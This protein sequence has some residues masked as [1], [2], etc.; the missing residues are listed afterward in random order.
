MKNKFCKIDS[1]CKICASN[2][3][4]L[5]LRLVLGGFILTHGIP[6]LMNFSQ[7]SQNFVPVLGSPTLGLILIIGAEVFCA[8]AIILGLFTRLASI[9][10]IIG[11]LVATIA[12]H[13][14]DPFKAMELSLLYAAMFT[15]IALVG[16]G[17]FSLDNIICNK[18]CNT[19][20][21]IEN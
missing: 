15:V 2:W 3:G 9:P 21:V 5:L 1:K 12:V 13:I 18:Y 17:K 19:K 16:P 4:L 7:L 20:E 6:K 8:I 14:N 11:M 10:P